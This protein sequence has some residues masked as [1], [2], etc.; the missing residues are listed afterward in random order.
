MGDV[1]KHDEVISLGK[2]HHLSRGSSI[3]ACLQPGAMV[4]FAFGILASHR[5]LNRRV[6]GVIPEV[7]EVVVKVTYILHNFIRRHSADKEDSG[8]TALCTEPSAGLHDVTQTGSNASR[9]A[10]TVKE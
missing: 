9:E 10:L 3:T 2:T 5:W 1:G 8:S 4:E 6:L 7:A